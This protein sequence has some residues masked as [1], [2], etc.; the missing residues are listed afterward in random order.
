MVTELNLQNQNSPTCK[1]QA[2]RRHLLKAQAHRE[3]NIA[4][5]FPCVAASVSLLPSC[6][7]WDTA[8][9]V[10]RITAQPPRNCP[11]L[12]G[13]ETELQILC[14]L[15]GTQR[16]FQLLLKNC[17]WKFHYPCNNPW[18]WT[19]RAT[20]EKSMNKY[21]LKVL[22]SAKP[23]CCWESHTS[24]MG[25]TDKAT[26][27]SC[28]SS[29]TPLPTP[30][31]QHKDFTKLQ[32]SLQER[33]KKSLLRK[34]FMTV[35]L[36]MPI[37]FPWTKG[38]QAAYMVLFLFL[39]WASA[40]VAKNKPHSTTIYVQQPPGECKP[41]PAL[42]LL[43][44]AQ[45]LCHCCQAMHITQL[46]RECLLHLFSF[47]D[48]NSRKNLAKT[49][50]KLLEVFQ[51]PLLWSLLNFHSPVE[52]KKDNFLLGPAL[53]YLSICWYSERVKVCNIEDWMKNS[54]Q[55]DFCNRHENTVSDFLLDVCNRYVLWVWVCSNCLEW[56][57]SYFKYS[58]TSAWNR[59]LST[60]ECFALTILMSC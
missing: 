33:K 40:P 15:Q 28:S 30:V 25:N 32:E 29:P 3:L 9:F 57:E 5:Q 50:H 11:C 34:H 39:F 24:Q 59:A 6:R 46:N 23:N 26:P 22:Y 41:P 17:L 44:E 31:T 2:N 14:V 12:W 48:K 58:I 60:W 52:L 37:A 36:Y 43:H 54:F 21:R 10:Y 19:K 1:I 27:G 55:K 18:T 56:S 7:R 42:L 13:L 16:M 45:R 8:S 49:C 53:K 51:D 38:A 35:K 4:L 20:S 47:L